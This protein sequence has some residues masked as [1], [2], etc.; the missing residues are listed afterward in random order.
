VLTRKSFTVIIDLQ[1]NKERNIMKDLDRLA[2]LAILE[3]GDYDVDT[4]FWC[5]FQADGENYDVNVYRESESSTD[6]Q[7]S[8]YGVRPCQDEDNWTT[9]IDNMVSSFN[10]NFTK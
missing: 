6:Y 4:D 9:D 2:I 1:T 10:F 7:V 5:S 3:D 8:I